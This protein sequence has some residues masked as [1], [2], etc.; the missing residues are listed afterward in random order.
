M[1][2]LTDSLTPTQRRI[3]EA[4]SDGLPRTA[5]QLH[6][7][8][9]DEQSAT[10]TVN[11]HISYLR[12]KLAEKDPG[13]GILIEVIKGRIHFRMVYLINHSAKASTPADVVS[14]S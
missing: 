1:A 14:S 12:K 2:L 4:L 5:K 9:W 7:L 10:G 11:R 6:S 8:L 13:V 3:Y